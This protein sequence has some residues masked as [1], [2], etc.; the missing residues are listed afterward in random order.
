MTT[1]PHDALFKAVFSVPAH[2]AAL[3]RAVLPPDLL[4]RL[5]L[6]TLQ[7]E[8]AS[9]IDGELAD[10][11]GDLMLSVEVRTATAGAPSR[12]LVYV[13]VEHQSRPDVDMPLR[14][15]G[16]LVEVW[17]RARRAE[18]AQPLPLIIP[19]VLSHAPGGWTAPRALRE[20]FA[21]DLVGDVTLA[22][23]WPS[24]PIIVEDLAVL[25]NADLAAR[26]PARVPRLTWW[27][28]RDAR[29]PSRL[30]ANVA[31]WAADLEQV[32][33][34]DPV[35]LAQLA[36]YL[37]LVAD[38]FSIDA[39]R[40]K[41]EQHAP[42]TAEAAMT[43]GELLI[44]QGLEKGIA[45]GIAQGIEQGIEQG[46]QQSLV[47]SVTRLLELRFGALTAAQRERLAAA[48]IVELEVSLERILFAASADAVLAP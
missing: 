31:P 9:F 46:R 10:L 25:S 2:A 3:C 7:H 37:T 45:Q 12:A 18:P 29:D 4:A 19:V 5:D 48:S 13:L 43:Y 32:A 6:A 38:P 1:R 44:Q 33:V 40:A 42:R 17:R 22:A 39:I 35:A 41:L 28:L 47:A 30:L 15:L 14:L 11:H 27:L 36:R 34:E 21:P 16:Y 24:L 23:L 8:P 20:L 26:V